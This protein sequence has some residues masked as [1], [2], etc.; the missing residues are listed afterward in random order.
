MT[1]V[2]ASAVG[3]T[4][5]QITTHEHGLLIDDPDDLAGFGAAIEK[6]PQ[7][8]GQAARLGH[9]ARRRAVIEFLGD[10]HLERRA[11]VLEALAT[12]T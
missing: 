10:R 2:A 5:D 8:P 12:K 7:D 6:L 11:G 1:R 9:N 3:G 4:V